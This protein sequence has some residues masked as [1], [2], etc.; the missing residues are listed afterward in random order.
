MTRLRPHSHL[1]REGIIAVVLFMT[2]VLVVL[3]V[4]T[5]ANGRWPV[6]FVLQVI[7]TALVVF[8]AWGYFGAAIWVSPE[9]ITERGFFGRKAT[10][11]RNQL[12]SV[13]IAETQTASLAET[14]PQLFVCDR[15]GTQVVRMRGQFWSRE[16]MELV[17]T[18]LDLPAIQV[19][20]AVTTRELLRDYPGLFYW[21]E[22][23]PVLAGLLFS[24]SLAVI[25]GLVM[26]F[27]FL[28]DAR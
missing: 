25:A 11:P 19:D 24:G 8:A 17:R 20:E 23:H 9:G 4:L 5:F 15:E 27:L 12:G 1:L 14:T 18:T 28:V 22:R 7:V 3:Y 21:F 26:V 6:V 2:P 16:N 10:F 13:V